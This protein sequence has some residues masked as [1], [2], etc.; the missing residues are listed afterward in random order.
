MFYDKIIASIPSG[1]FTLTIDLDP[2]LHF[3]NDTNP[4]DEI[5][6]ETNEV[7]GFLKSRLPK[8]TFSTSISPRLV[9][10]VIT[11]IANEQQA[12]DAMKHA[13]MLLKSKHFRIIQSGIDEIEIEEDE[14]DTLSPIQ[15]KRK[16]EMKVKR[17]HGLCPHCGLHSKNCDK[18]YNPQRSWK[19]HRDTQ[20][21]K[22]A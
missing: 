18:P 6:K 17:E 13:E 3:D 11:N 21:K 20:Y 1:K 9:I 22:S 12:K 8:A 2:H 15:L 16:Y 19:E 14:P 10:F 4:E 7:W 5:E